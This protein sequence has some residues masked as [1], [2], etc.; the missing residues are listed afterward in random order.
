MTKY[1]TGRYVIT[2]FD[3]RGTK[4]GQFVS[5]EGGLIRA[6]EIGANLIKEKRCHSFNVHLNVFN[7]MDPK[8]PW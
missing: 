3:E 2:M 6:Q 4:I 1:V 7:S 8:G 5:K